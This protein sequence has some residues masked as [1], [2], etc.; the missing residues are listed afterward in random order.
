MLLSP[1]EVTSRGL[2]NAAPRDN[3]ILELGLFVGA[4]GRRRALMVQPEKTKLKLPTD[5]L[6]VI[7]IRYPDS[8][9]Q[10][11]T[12]SIQDIIAELGCR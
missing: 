6:G 2:V 12:P 10:E 11:A 1:D 7:A 3:I 5:L 8:S 4:L 9:V